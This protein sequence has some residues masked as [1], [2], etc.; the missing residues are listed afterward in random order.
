M[1]FS[2][3]CSYHHGKTKSVKICH[4][5]SI[6]SVAERELEWE[7]RRWFV[8]KLVTLKGT[9]DETVCVALRGC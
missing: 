3:G 9:Q 4:F 1:Y 2:C 7:S 8:V 6:F 5:E